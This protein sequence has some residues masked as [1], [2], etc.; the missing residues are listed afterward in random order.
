[1]LDGEIIESNYEV[2]VP[3]STLIL[4]IS[5]DFSAGQH[6]VSLV[7]TDKSAQSSQKDV[8][9]NFIDITAPEIAVL[10]SPIIETIVGERILLQNFA[11]DNESEDLE[12]TWIIDQGSENEIELLD[13]GPQVFYEFQSKGTKNV[14]L[15]VENDA[16]LTSYLEILVIVSEDEDDSGLGII[17]IGGI[18]VLLITIVSIV[19]FMAYNSAVSRNCLL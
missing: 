13:S 12:Y 18:I 6:V 7:V 15:I 2:S 1:M 3:N 17:A 8:L 11:L 19:S 4:A 5:N 10:G 16:G 9:V 14:L